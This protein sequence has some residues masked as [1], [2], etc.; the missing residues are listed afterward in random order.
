MNVFF[1][2]WRQ[3][4]S[5]LIMVRRCGR[6][7]SFPHL[8]PISAARQPPSP[9]FA[10]G[11]GEPL[12][13]QDQTSGFA[14]AVLDG[15]VTPSRQPPSPAFAGGGGEPLQGQDQ[16]SGVAYAMLDGAVTK[17]ILFFRLCGAMMG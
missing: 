10:G 15:A 13:G 4:L 16:T 11:G 1:S 5:S 6:R 9:A 8:N 3:V 12:Q 7:R 2:L 17:M 14:H